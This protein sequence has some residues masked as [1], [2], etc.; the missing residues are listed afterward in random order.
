MFQF[1]APDVELLNWKDRA[2]RV[3]K[4][5]AA[6]R[7]VRTKTDPAEL[8]AAIGSITFSHEQYED[9]AWTIS[10]YERA[11]KLLIE[12]KAPAAARVQLLLDYAGRL[13]LREQYVR[14]VAIER[15]AL[16]LATESDLRARTRQTLVASLLSTG[17]V[18]EPIQILTA[19]SRDIES[20]AESRIIAYRDLAQLSRRLGRTKDA[21]LARQ[22]WTEFLKTAPEPQARNWGWQQLAELNRDWKQSE[23]A[24]DAY[25]Q[26]LAGA[27][28]V[29]E[30]TELYRY[31]SGLPEAARRRI[32]SEVLGRAKE[33]AGV[34]GLLTALIELAQKDLEDGR[35]N[36]AR[37]RAVKAAQALRDLPPNTA[38]KQEIGHWKAEISDL[39]E[40][41]QSAKEGERTTA[42]RAISFVDDEGVP[43]SA[44]DPAVVKAREEGESL[45]AALN[46]SAEDRQKLLSALPDDLKARF[47]QL[48]AVYPPKDLL[49][50]NASLAEKMKRLD[51]KPDFDTEEGWI[52]LQDATKVGHYDW[53]IAYAE[54]RLK[55]MAVASPQFFYLESTVDSLLDV[56]AAK[57][58][59]AAGWRTLG[60]WRDVIAETDH[61]E[62]TLVDKVL[63]SESQWAERSG[64]LE[65]QRT[66]LR[67]RIDFA[68]Q[69]QGEKSNAARAARF[70]YARTLRRHGNWEQAKVEW[71]ILL[72][73]PPKENE[74]G[75][76]RSEVALAFEEVVEAGD[77]ATFEAW[78]KRLSDIGYPL[79]DSEKRVIAKAKSKLRPVGG[80]ARGQSHGPP[81][82]LGAT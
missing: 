69:V 59:W 60:W 4:R 80:D 32:A 34:K 26:K 17:E 5:E 12:R 48:T 57:K 20:D 47:E 72:G 71:E 75:L 58:D 81:P 82:P 15:R 51:A 3:A 9:L 74:F 7:K 38:T 61:P 56:F 52:V 11:E 31:A 44:D 22:A 50:A 65:R 35:V 28:E 70:Q 18:D 27:G 41:V 55:R 78:E 43:L 25:R 40:A 73:L 36:E 24:V 45:L 66:I 49:P 64:D 21:E 29:R 37:P 2:D 10:A 30:I 77:P 46:G 79:S 23:A 16:D 68:A 1:Q 6:W 8:V 53:A 39:Q 13:A 63:W 67:S 76:D 33:A 62:S 19:A 14:G 54:P 42:R